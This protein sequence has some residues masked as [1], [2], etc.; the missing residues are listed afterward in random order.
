VKQEELN[1]AMLTVTMGEAW[2]KVKEGLDNEIRNLEIRE[3]NANDFSAILEL[4][5]YRKALTWVRNWRQTY[6]LEKTNAV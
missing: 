6:K 2:E 4:R 3:L 1:E 5:G